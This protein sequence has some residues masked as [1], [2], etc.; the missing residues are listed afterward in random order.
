MAAL[1]R[2]LRTADWVIYAIG[3]EQRDGFTAAFNLSE[4]S[5]TTGRLSAPSSW[6]FGIAFPN[7][8]TLP[9]GTVHKDVSLLAFATHIAKQRQDILTEWRAKRNVD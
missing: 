5:G 1:A 6:G 9:D 3:F 8:T 7:T 2:A 4:Y